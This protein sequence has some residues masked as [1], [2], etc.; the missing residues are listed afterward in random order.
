L[1]FNSGPATSR[2]AGDGRVQRPRVATV[3]CVLGRCRPGVRAGRRSW[4]DVLAGVLG[5]GTRRHFRRC[6]RWRFWK[7]SLAAVLRA[8][9]GG[10]ACVRARQRFLEAFS[11]AVLAC[12]LGGDARVCAALMRPGLLAWWATP[13]ALAC[14]RGGR[15]PALWPAHVEVFPLGCGAASLCACR[16]PCFVASWLTWVLAGDLAVG[17]IRGGLQWGDLA[18]GRRRPRG[19]AG[20]CRGRLFVGDGSFLPTN[21]GDKPVGIAQILHH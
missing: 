11:A 9:P 18:V 12:V 7:A 19:G 13:D 2:R 5:G 4:G 16:R 1:T 3:A 10:G 15:R 6:A 8:V 14:S 20:D 21:R 17:R